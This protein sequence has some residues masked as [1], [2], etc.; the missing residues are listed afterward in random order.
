M[1]FGHPGDCGPDQKQQQNAQDFPDPDRDRVLLE[2]VIDDLSQAEEYQQDGPVT[3]GERPKIE[4]D[5][6]IPQQEQY[7]ESGPEQGS[8]Q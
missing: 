4:S 6:E 2:E 5:S 8:Q 3:T 7:S 1:A